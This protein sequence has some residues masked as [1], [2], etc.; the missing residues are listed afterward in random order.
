ML[1]NKGMLVLAPLAIVGAIVM[2]SAVSQQQ[3]TVATAVGQADTLSTAFRAAADRVLPTVVKIRSTQSARQVRVDPGD[4]SFGN[5]NPFRGTPLEDF[6]REFEGR[7][8]RRIIP[9]REGSGSGVIMNAEGLILTNNHVVK[10]ADEVVVELSDGRVFEAVDIRTDPETDIAV[11][12]IETDEPLPSARLGDSDESQIGDW[13][14]AVGNPFELEAS[15]SAGIISAR[16]RSLGSAASRATFLQTD[17]AINPGNSGG[18]LVNMRGEVI[19]INTAI[20][21]SSGGYQGIGFSIPINLAKWVTKQLIEDGEVRRGYLGVVIGELTH[22]LAKVLG[23]DPRTRGVV[24]SQVGSG[25]PAAAAG[26]KP[27]DLITHFGQRQVSDPSSLQRAVEQVELG[28]RQ[29][30]KV[31]RDGRELK[32]NV[33]TEALPPKERSAQRRGRIGTDRAPAVTNDL[34]LVVAELDEAS[35]RALRLENPRGVVITRVAPGGPAA[36]AGLSKG[37][38]IIR[39][40]GRPVTTAEQFEAAISNEEKDAIPMVVEV[41]EVGT[42]FVVLERD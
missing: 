33:V 7:G 23:I 8:G 25:T 19:G 30:L 26:V 17:A 24:V 41:P 9:R 21:S 3:A 35:A 38:A 29:T 11:V 15:V 18:P 16:G 28:S 5:E 4:R 32:L 20:A 13:V 40:N 14:L 34:G 42:R 27:G 22:D 1:K 39:V 6:Y 2:G 12:R 36:K 10:D 37:M 31:I